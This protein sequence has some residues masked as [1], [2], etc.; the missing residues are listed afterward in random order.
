M[1]VLLEKHEHKFLWEEALGALVQIHISLEKFNDSTSTTQ[2]FKERTKVIFLGIW[3]AWRHCQVTH[4][5][6]NFFLYGDIAR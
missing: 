6:R 2:R 3:L 5:A 1:F 4:D